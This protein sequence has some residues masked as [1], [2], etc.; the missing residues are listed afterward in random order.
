MKSKFEKEFKNQAYSEVP[1]KLEEIQKKIKMTEN[2]GNI[3]NGFFGRKTVMT[4]LTTAAAVAVTLVVA[5]SLRDADDLPKAESITETGT[6]RS[7]ITESDTATESVTAH[8]TEHEALIHSELTTAKKREETTSKVTHSETTT[9]ALYTE[10]YKETDWDRRS[11][12]GKF[13]GAVFSDNGTVTE[14]VYPRSYTEA[15]MTDRHAVLI[16]ENCT[17][18]N[19]NPKTDEA[20]TAIAD[21]YALEGF[22]KELAVGIKF[23]GADGIYTYVNIQ[24][25]PKTLGEFLEAVDYFN[26]VSYGGTELFSGRRVPVNSENAND[27]KEYLFSDGTVKN[28]E[29]GTEG[30]YVTVTVSCDELGLSSKTLRIYKNGYITTNLI[31][32]Q[33][34][35]FVGE[36]KTNAF[37]QNS[38]NITFSEIEKMLEQK[39]QTKTDP[40]ATTSYRPEEDVV[41]MTSKRY[42]PE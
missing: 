34:T 30:P 18:T 25:V 38:Y 20:V 12:P 14:Y 31:G 27:I 36:E 42:I 29:R 39:N 32:F 24:Y 23:E 17:L 22:S 7:E 4:V 21:I 26:T 35:F 10:H 13:P 41:V 11:L 37:L 33:Y 8:G 28:T 5:F 19:R 2:H 15:I 9:R 6:V 16:R 40:T 3:K 1:D